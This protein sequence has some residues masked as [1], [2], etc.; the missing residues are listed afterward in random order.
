MSALHAKS[1]QANS[2]TTPSVTGRQATISREQTASLDKS[3]VQGIAWTGAVKWGAQLLSWLGTIV[4][5]RILNPEDFGLVA[6]AGVLLGLIAVFNDF[7]LGAAVVVMRNLT[8][9]QIARTHGLSILFGVAGFIL[10]CLLAIPMG[11]YYGAPE[12][13]L[14]F[15]TMGTELVL[16]AMRSVP[17]AIL[18]RELRF[19]FVALLEGWQAIV[20][21]LVTVSLAWWGAG[22]WAL[23][24]G[25]LLGGAGVT[26]VVVAYRPLR[27]AWPLMGVL[28][29]I[30]RFGSRVLV[31]RV[32]WYVSASSDLFI[33]G[34]ALGGAILGTYSFAVS[35]SNVPMEKVT[36]LA[37]RVMPAF[38]S[39]VQH[40]VAAMRRYFLTL[41]E[42]L[43]LITFPLAGG[44]RLWRRTLC[45]WLWGTNGRVS[46]RR[47]RYWR[48]GLQFD[49]LPV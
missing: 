41:T 26:A 29:E 27:P 22:Y 34:W 8:N 49:R 7:G 13:P 25:R 45:R 39:T 37:S 15:M 17:K 43:A 11:Q 5:A 48:V 16:I 44:W 20:T 33:A 9:D 47:C 40:D 6:M 38:Y 4:V 35:I 14:I 23:V 10:V 46:S 31:S 19:K 28:R 32:A 24:G 30:I 21:I 36:A 18:E 42:G 1:P 2:V 3:L 12:V